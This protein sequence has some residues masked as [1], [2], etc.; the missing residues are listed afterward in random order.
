[1]DEEAA[2]RR[3]AATT[4]RVFDERERKRAVLAKLAVEARP[5]L[6]ARRNGEG[7]KGEGG[8]QYPTVF[9]PP[10]DGWRPGEV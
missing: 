7:G 8:L 6:A 2:A 3:K 5:V 1:M 10:A 4:R 9:E